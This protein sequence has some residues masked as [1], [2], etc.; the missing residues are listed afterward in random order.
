MA[1]PH[2]HVVL[3]SSGVPS[4]VLGALRRVGATT[5]FST[6]GSALRSD[7]PARADAVIVVSENE[8][9]DQR[10]QIGRLLSRLA[11]EAP[12]TLLVGKSQRAASG[13]RC[14][15]DLPIG[16]DRSGDER[17]IAARLRTLLSTHAHAGLRSRDTTAAN[18]SSGQPAG[19]TSDARLTAR[20][21]KA[22]APRRLPALG[23]FAFTTIYRPA[24]GVSGDFYDIYPLDPDH[25][26]V[27]LADATGHGLPAATLTAFVRRAARASAVRR[28]AGGLCPADMLTR[29][30]RMLV[31]CDLEDCR[32]V[33]AA[34]AVLNVRTRQVSL[35]RGGTPYPIVRRVGGRCELLKS[36]G[37]LVGI[38][39]DARF[40]VE[41][42][43]LG[44]GDWLM[45]Y[46]D[47]V[48]PLVDEIR[49][50]EQPALPADEAIGGSDW[51]RRLE[52]NPATAVR[53][54]GRRHDV[55]RRIGRSMDDLT[56]V[57]IHSRH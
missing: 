51:F 1:S 39:P 55:L 50:A 49:A 13:L 19:L 29:I 35:A 3:A 46:S 45:L 24:D 28:T 40:D 44:P 54:L 47:G 42:F 38:D 22:L 8:N 4:G 16:F 25:V 18:S 20:L 15:A 33:A 43:R 14:P 32:F 2:V 37:P 34:F 57:A 6:L 30:N 12:A 23:P 52:A 21:R 56:V 26:A 7:R 11:P 9:R 31:E 36:A 17:A 5:R 48:E 41:H 27:T 10:R 53:W